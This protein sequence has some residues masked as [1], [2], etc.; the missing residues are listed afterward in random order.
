MSKLRHDQVLRKFRSHLESIEGMQSV[1]AAGYV[2]AARQFLLWAGRRRKNWSEITLDDASRYWAECKERYAPSTANHHLKSLKALYRFGEQQRL[3]NA[4]P[5]YHMKRAVGEPEKRATLTFDDLERIKAYRPGDDWF[6]QRDR[7]LVLFLLSTGMR[8]T[9]CTR[10]DLDDLH[11]AQHR[12]RCRDKG[13][14][15]HW[16]PIVAPAREALE[17]WVEVLRPLR[18]RP[19]ERALWISR[20]G[21][22]IDKATVRDA[23]SRVMRACG[24]E[25]RFTPH[26]LRRTAGTLMRRAGVKKED[27]QLFY[28][29]KRLQTTE[30]YLYEDEE[31]G[32]EVALQ[33][34][35]L[36]AVR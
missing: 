4:N 3:V 13:N 10:V 31:R 35:P 27:I 2:S 15:T 7:A 23:L 29:H 25:D 11:L 8:V 16:K 28:G 30:I 18:A 20:F 32:V 6:A 22:R 26:D 14:R 19:G 12:V 5:W 1:T 34:H 24:I 17:E 36:L 33:H 9:A 21:Q